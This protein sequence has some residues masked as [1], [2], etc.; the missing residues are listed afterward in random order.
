[1]GPTVTV[2]PIRDG[3]WVV[4]PVGEFDAQTL[5]GL[6]E[7]CRQAVAEPGLERLVLDLRG[8]SFADS[9]FLNLLLTLRIQC[10]LLLW[11]PLPPRL[12][13]L[14]KITGARE[15]FAVE[16]GPDEPSAD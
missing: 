13:R 6:K 1:M 5:E 16:D 11:G 3:L 10:D 4:R 8:V 7:A 2:A 15:L 14:L 12:T 9:S